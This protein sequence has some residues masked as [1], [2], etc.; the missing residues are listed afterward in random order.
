MHAA[1]AKL[2]SIQ[3]SL[4]ITG[5]HPWGEGG[6]GIRGNAN[7]I[8]NEVMQL[9]SSQRGG[10]ACPAHLLWC[11][12]APAQLVGQVSAVLKKGTG[13]ALLLFVSGRERRCSSSAS[14]WAGVFKYLLRRLSEVSVFVSTPRPSSIWT[15]CSKSNV[16]GFNP[17]RGRKGGMCLLHPEHFI[18][19]DPLL[20]F[21][22]CLIFKVFKSKNL[23][24]SA[25]YEQHQDIPLLASPS[26]ASTLQCEP[27]YQRFASLLSADLGAELLCSA[28]SAALCSAQ[29]LA[30]A[31]FRA[32]ALSG[33]VAVLW[34]PKTQPSFDLLAFLPSPHTS[35]CLLLSCAVLGVGINM[36]DH[37]IVGWPLH[38][39]SMG[40]NR[41]GISLCFPPSISIII[42]Y[43]GRS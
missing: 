36:S 31:A 8:W 30:W 19:T 5:M 17:A 15:V 29:L 39:M 28:V 42:K 27:W 13:A 37:L 25:S 18:Y 12:A 40:Q 6:H 10:S 2:I 33:V 24:C 22:T 4:E 9:I 32:P 11:G 21:F 43:M 1:S 16:F 3:G 41:M 34:M 14:K 23:P 20:F 7:P 38:F 26:G 35:N